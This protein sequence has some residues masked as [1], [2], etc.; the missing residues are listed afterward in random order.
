MNSNLLYQDSPFLPIVHDDD[1]LEI[2]QNIKQKRVSPLAAIAT[3]SANI[4]IALNTLHEN[5]IEWIKSNFH[6]Y[7][8]N[9]SLFFFGFSVPAQLILS[10][11]HMG[12]ANSKEVIA[13]LTPK[14]NNPIRSQLSVHLISLLHDAYYITLNTPIDRPETAIEPII[15][16]CLKKPFSNDEFY[17]AGIES[18][19][20]TL[21]KLSTGF[22]LLNKIEN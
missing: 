18:S 6:C 5:E 9:I 3:Q 19:Q 7:E 10:G 21:E 14:T 11:L 13:N 1:I 17:L 22:K 2:I 16:C 15:K 8:K 20:I 12:T 4:G